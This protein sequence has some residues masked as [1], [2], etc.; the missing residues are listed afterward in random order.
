MLERLNVLIVSSNA[1]KLGPHSG[2]PSKHSS[3]G[4]YLNSKDFAPN[5]KLGRSYRASL[6]DPQSLQDELPPNT[7]PAGTVETNSPGS[8]STANKNLSHVPCKFYKQGICQAGKSCPFSHDFDG[9]TSADKLPCKYFQKGNCKFGLKCALAHYLPD[10]TRVNNKG[11]LSYRRHNDRT[12]R[13]RSQLNLMGNT[14]YNSSDSLSYYY[15]TSPS[16]LSSTTLV[17]TNGTSPESLYNNSYANLHERTASTS[18]MPSMPLG[19]SR[20][21]LL[22]SPS[23]TSQIQDAFGSGDWL[24]RPIFNFSSNLFS[25]GSS[26]Y[27][28]VN[29]INLSPPDLFRNTLLKDSAK[30]P[31]SSVSLSSFN[32]QISGNSLSSPSSPVYIFNK[33]VS[34]DAVITDEADG[35]DEEPFFEDYVPASLGNLILTPQEKQRRDSR[36]QSGTLLVRPN[37]NKASEGSIDKS[38]AQLLAT[39]EEESVFLMD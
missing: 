16:I 1:Y 30:V 25:S 13:A 35:A 21:N 37:V 29:G 3:S 12:E 10:G 19:S 11:S 17:D 14:M 33:C 18:S 5:P 39:K 28:L 9:S 38:W 6:H 36:S 32:M 7:G 31:T 27:A 2:P 26:N 20:S 8:L 34:E 15:K 23:T 22:V 24:G 4:S